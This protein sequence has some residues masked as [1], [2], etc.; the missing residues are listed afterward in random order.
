MREA[1]N[2]QKIVPGGR[3]VKDVPW[4]RGWEIWM[5]V[6]TGDRGYGLPGRPAG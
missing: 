1:E 6:D 3:N 2:I 5:I 4:F